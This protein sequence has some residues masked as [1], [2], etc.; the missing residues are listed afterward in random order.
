MPYRRANDRICAGNDNKNSR[1]EVASMHHHQLL[2]QFALRI[3]AFGLISPRS[4]HCSLRHTLKEYRSAVARASAFTN[5]G[6]SNGGNQTDIAGSFRPEAV[7][8]LENASTNLAQPITTSLS[9]YDYAH[10]DSPEARQTFRIHS[11]HRILVPGN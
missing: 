4:M 6:H 2:I 10:P 9:R 7:V 1:I 3:F 11:Q 8:D 5:S